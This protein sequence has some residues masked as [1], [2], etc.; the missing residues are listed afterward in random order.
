MDLGA[1]DSLFV[2]FFGVPAATVP[3]VPRLAR[4]TGAKVVPCVTRMTRRG[5]EVT[6]F[7]PW[8]GYPSEDLTADT[9]RMNAF[10]EEQVRTMPEQYYWVHRRFKTRPPGEARLY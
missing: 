8:D 4:L 7:P 6:L 2:P 10:I 9:R 3:G 5:Y 1:Q